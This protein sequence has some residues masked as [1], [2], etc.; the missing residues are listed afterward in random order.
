MSS[1]AVIA[2]VV[3]AVVVLGAISFLT[4][5]RRTDVRGAGALSRETKRRD[6]DAEIDLPAGPTGK[7]VERAA[8]SARSTSLVKADDM[9]P[10]V[11]VPPDPEAL[12]V[13]RRQFFN[14]ATVG[15]TTTGLLSFAAAGFV[16]FLWPIAK[17]GFGGKV[18]VGKRDE[19]ISSI[20]SS[21]GFFYA[22]E[23]RAWITEY[24][25]SALPKAE[26]V[27][28]PAVLASLE[29]G[30]MASYQKCPHLGCRVPSCTSSQWFECPCH[31]SQYNKVG[32]KKAGP[33]PRGLDHFAFTV[34]GSGDVV[35]D[36]GTIYQGRPIGTNTTGQEA[37]GPH[38]I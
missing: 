31:G 37:E 3:A 12:G 10:A 7:E 22:S 20:R 26:G 8:S 35:I 1:A 19:I 27:Y 13:S 11:F 9:A 4:V 15:L 23:A 28:Q 38:C 6:R 16:A 17:G 30:L 5:A 29:Q 14:R 21:G 33:A 18:N 34:S 2:I 24:P 32:E 25:S 36:T